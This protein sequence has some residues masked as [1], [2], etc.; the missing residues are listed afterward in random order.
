M[1]IWW[2]DGLGCTAHCTMTV[3]RNESRAERTMTQRLCSSRL[4]SGRE[5]TKAHTRPSSARL[6]EAW[7]D[8]GC[9]SA[10]RI[11][12]FQNSCAPEPMPSAA[13]RLSRKNSVYRK[14]RASALQV[15]R[16]VVVDAKK[17]QR[18]RRLNW[19]VDRVMMN[20]PVGNSFPPNMS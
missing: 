13:M 16:G 5:K 11:V 10:L 8:T 7:R 18:H 3:S 1:C 19:P 17:S 2:S 12:G 4:Q 9:G 6:S 15:R 20:Q 14:Q